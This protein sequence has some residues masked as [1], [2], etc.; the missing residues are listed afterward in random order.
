MYE[1]VYGKT[2]PR[3]WL[4]E[5]AVTLPMAVD[6]PCYNFVWLCSSVTK[7]TD[8]HLDRLSNLEKST[9]VHSAQRAA[10]CFP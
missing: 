10:T 9:S 8:G 1:H 7:R 3:F 5:N 2:P 6:R 4:G